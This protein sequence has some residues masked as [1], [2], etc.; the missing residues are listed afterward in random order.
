MDLRDH[1]TAAHRA[2][3]E[4]ANLRGYFVWTILDNFEWAH[5]YTAK[6]GLVSVDR[7][8]L[9]RTPKASYDWFARIAQTNAI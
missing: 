4:G 7:A 6:F 3:A 8:T 9:T 5:G 2:I 1:I